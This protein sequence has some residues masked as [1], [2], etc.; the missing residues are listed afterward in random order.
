MVN[1]GWG[2]FSG[3][4]IYVTVTETYTMRPSLE[5]SFDDPDFPKLL[6]QCQEM[7]QWFPHGLV[8]I[9]GIAVYMHAINIE[10][11][12]EFAEATHDADLYISMADMGDLR[13][14]EEVTPNRRLGKSQ[15]VKGGFEFDIYT[16]RQ[17][18]LIVPY[19]M[20]LAESIVYGQVRVAS[21]EV[22]F[23]LKLEAYLDRQNSEKGLKDAKD[24][25]RLALIA[26][27]GAGR[28]DA[29][30]IAPYVRDA[31]LPLLERVERGP[32]PV[33]MARGNAMRAKAMRQDFAWV[34]QL[35]LGALG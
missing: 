18:S 26:R 33:M 10:A 23:A 17:S 6:A 21:I 14:L 7:A 15:I 31:H 29:A 30:L 1:L 32:A 20:V 28:F 9:G 34:S 25:L 2:K 24:L 8:Y 5:P 3:K 16:E 4:L 22:L 35:V 12:R 13:D 11:V 19:D 27:K